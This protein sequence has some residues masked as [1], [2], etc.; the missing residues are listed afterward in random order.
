MA[1]WAT[2]HATKVPFVDTITLTQMHAPMQDD[3]WVPLS[4]V[5]SFELGLFG[6][7]AEGN[8]ACVFSDYV[9]G[10]VS[11]DIM[12]EVVY[13][14]EEGANKRSQEYWDTLRPI[15]LTSEEVLDYSR[16]DSIKLVR[17]DPAYLDSLDREAN[18]FK[19]ASILT[20]YDHGNRKAKSR[21]SI[22]VSYTHLTLPTT[23]YV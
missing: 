15:P 22:T 1:L 19:I 21:W 20:G 2:K 17:E 14:V 18:N 23:P 7:E 5:I 10:Q 4:S 9:V 6:F 8:F 12:D 3:Q 16:K 11:D 13:V